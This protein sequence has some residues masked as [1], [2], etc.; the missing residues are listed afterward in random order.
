[1]NWD[2]SKIFFSRFVAISQNERNFTNYFALLWWW[3]KVVKKKKKKM[4]D[5]YFPPL[6]RSWWWWWENSENRC[7]TNLS[8][9]DWTRATAFIVENDNEQKI[10]DDRSNDEI[11]IFNLTGL[12]FLNPRVG[13]SV[14]VELAKWRKCF[15]QLLDSMEKNF[16][17][18]S[19]NI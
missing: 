4:F 3:R 6:R 15:V 18:T 9:W 16:Q 7:S 13:C 8:N 17:K 14:K 19:I 1:M 2:A 11:F 10:Y 5:N 12:S